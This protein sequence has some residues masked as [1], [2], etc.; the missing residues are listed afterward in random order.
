MKPN[1]FEQVKQVLKG[2]VTTEEVAE[3]ETIIE[4][5]KGK[6]LP[7]LSLGFWQGKTPRWK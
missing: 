2:G 7:G 1:E 5:A 3:I 6:I 4:E